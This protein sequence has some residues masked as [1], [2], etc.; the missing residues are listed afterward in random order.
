MERSVVL[1]V[2]NSVRMILVGPVTSFLVAMLFSQKEQGVY[3]LFRSLIGM[4]VAAEFGLPLILSPLISHEWST[5]RK[6]R[7]ASLCRKAVGFYLVSSPLAAAILFWIGQRTISNSEHWESSWTV[8]W[9]ATCAFCMIDFSLRPFLVILEGCQRMESALKIRLFQ[10]LM[11]ALATWVT[12]GAG[13]SLL[14]LAC[15]YLAS[16]LVGLTGLFLLRELFLPILRRTSDKLSWSQEIWP[17]QWRLG[18]GSL[19]SAYSA[20]MIVKIVFDDRGPEAAGRLGLAMA[21][22]QLLLMVSYSWVQT[23]APQ[24]ALL[25]AQGQRQELDRSFSRILRLQVLTTLLGMGCILAGIALLHHYHFRIATRL[26]EFYPLTLLLL[27]AFLNGL[28]AAWSIYVRAHREEPYL[29]VTLVFSVA[30]VATT[31]LLTHQFGV[32]GACWAQLLVPALAFPWQFWI[33]RR[34]RRRHQQSGEG[35]L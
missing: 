26:V 3:Y 17:L 4:S 12:I 11:M 29:G 24:I 9:A 15:G 14:S 19:G 31:V 27:S 5:G 13:G 32:L 2:L 20:G 23:K 8:A 34:C 30:M 33:W 10:G 7:W 16:I 28:F 6:D 22:S 25:V 1:S 35:V 18:L 21:V